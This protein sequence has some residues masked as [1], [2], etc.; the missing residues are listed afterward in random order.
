MQNKYA[1]NLLQ[2]QNIEAKQWR[3]DGKGIHRNMD[4]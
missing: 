1:E 2:I 4:L 3:G